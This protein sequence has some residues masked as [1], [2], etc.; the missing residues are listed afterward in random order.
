MPSK[1]PL[2]GIPLDYE[3]PSLKGD[4]LR[5]YSRSPWYAL[6]EDYI[7][8]L[9]KAGA[10]P[11]C[12]PYQEEDSDLYLDKLDGL[13][14]PGGN[15]MNPCLYGETTCHPSVSI[16]PRRAE[17]EISLTKKAL[18]RGMPILGICAGLQIINVTL[19]GTLFQHIP[20]M[21]PNA[22]VH[23]DR[24]NPTTVR[25]PITIN[26]NTRLYS[27]IGENATDWTVNS[28]HHQSIK[29][30]GKDL[31]ISAVAPDGIIEAIESR[32][33]RFVLGI[34]WHPEYHVCSID[35][36]IFKAFVEACCV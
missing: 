24:Q 35:K 31:I 6:R 26:K 14:L 28:N 23:Q 30:L 18:E 22:L 7:I 1:K 9:H 13:L 4:I 16:T 10:L 19:G 29:G 20:D 17:F 2:I 15:D 27:I 5:G 8:S 33:H 25:H 11:I 34:Q 36:F 21:V 3:L 32:K 12:I